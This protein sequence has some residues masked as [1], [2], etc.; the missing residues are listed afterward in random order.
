MAD[1]LLADS[2][3]GLTF[4][5]VDVGQLLPAVEVPRA[6]QTTIPATCNQYL[7]AGSDSVA[8][9]GSNN[10]S[11]IVV[12]LYD[13]DRMYSLISERIET[14]PEIE[15]LRSDLFYAQTNTSPL[16]DAHL[17]DHYGLFGFNALTVHTETLGGGF[18]TPATSMQLVGLVDETT[19]VVMAL[20][21]DGAPDLDTALAIFEAQA[22]KI[23]AAS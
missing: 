13:G 22:A 17:P 12:Q 10:D 18:A 7:L 16:S 2:S 14:C 19:V 3:Q 1:L 5:P 11:S 21:H 15:I 20:G 4:H 9:V 6:D 8:A 23:V